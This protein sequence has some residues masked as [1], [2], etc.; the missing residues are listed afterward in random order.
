M[1]FDISNVS[2]ED[3]DCVKK[4]CNPS[5]VFNSYNWGEYKRKQGWDIFRIVDS[6][7]KNLKIQLLVKK[8]YFFSVVWC[9]GIEILKNIKVKSELQE[10][11]KKILKIKI[12]YLRIRFSSANKIIHQNQLIKDGWKKSMF[13]L[14]TNKTLIYDLSDHYHDIKAN[15]LFSKNWKRNLLRSKKYKNNIS[16][17]KN[18][19][20]H[21]IFRLY[22]DLEK[23]K[24][25][26]Q[27]FSYKDIQSMI[28]IFDKD[29]IIVKC[30]DANGNIISIRGAILYNNIALDMFAV[31]S[32]QAKKQYSN[33][34]TFWK[35]FE[36]C[37]KN[38]ISIYDLGGVDKVNNKSVYNFKKGIGSIEFDSLGEYDWSNV[39][40]FRTL[41]GF[42]IKF[43]KR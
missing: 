1:R 15:N 5:N 18:P 13:P 17:W 11:I 6:S 31:S 7:N 24:K 14:S 20:A 22:Q 29:L 2:K 3:W 26:P 21:K 42:L 40:F 36:I 37:S 23:Y 27:Q 25:I 38:N 8:Y 41:L 30:E 33:Y 28:K 43:F 35:L 4:T 10:S 9:P 39:I 34:S 12:I 32:Y 19:D 16:I